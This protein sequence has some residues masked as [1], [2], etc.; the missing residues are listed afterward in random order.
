MGDSG[1]TFLGAIIALTILSTNSDSFYLWTAFAM[2]LPLVSDAIYTLIRRLC[3]QENI[4]QPHRTHLYQRLQQR[5]WSHPQ[6]A[7]S[8]A[9]LTLVMGGIIFFWGVTGVFVGIGVIIGCIVAAE[10]YLKS[11][12]QTV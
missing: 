10:Y 12:K 2:T 11:H 4:F 3:N 9:L 6:V 5:G 8:Y 1:S 7:T